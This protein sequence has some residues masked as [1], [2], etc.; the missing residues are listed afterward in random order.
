MVGGATEA[1]RGYHSGGAGRMMCVLS[2]SGDEVGIVERG[3]CD[4]LTRAVI[5]VK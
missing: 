3:L 2:G 4:A 1:G 5:L